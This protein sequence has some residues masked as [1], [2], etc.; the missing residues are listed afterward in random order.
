MSLF[1]DFIYKIEKEQNDYPN[2][3]KISCLKDKIEIDKN[4]KYK[5]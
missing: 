4:I 3:E 1:K 2:E 5:I